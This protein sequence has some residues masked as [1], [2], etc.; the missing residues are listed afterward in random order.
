MVGDGMVLMVGGLTDGW[1]YGL[2]SDR[3]LF[4]VGLLTCLLRFAL[5][6]RFNCLH[7]QFCVRVGHKIE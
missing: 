4:G 3:G 1:V 2:G 6:W 7:W 5:T